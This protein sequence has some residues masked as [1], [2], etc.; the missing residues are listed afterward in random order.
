MDKIQKMLRAKT[1]EQKEKLTDE[2]V[3][4]SQVFLNMILYLLKT[5][6]KG[7][8]I[9]LIFQRK[10][11]LAPGYTDGS[12]LFASWDNSIV[13]F[14]HDRIARYFAI[15]GIIFHEI[16][17]I[18]F[19]NFKEKRKCLDR[20]L[21]GS[22]P[23]KDPVPET[24]EQAEA[25]VAV[26]KAMADL[27]YR[28]LFLEVLKDLENSATDPHDERKMTEKF[29][30]FVEKAITFA[31]ES[32]RSTL[33]PFEVLS[34]KKPV[35]LALDTAFQYARFSSIFSVDASTVEQNEVAQRILSVKEHIDNARLTD[36]MTERY[37]ELSYVL[38]AIWP[39]IEQ[40]VGEKEKEEE[41]DQKPANA[42][43]ESDSDNSSGSSAGTE[44]SEEESGSGESESDED[45]DS[46]EAEKSEKSGEPGSGSESDGQGRK[47]PEVPEMSDEQLEDLLQQV[48]N[49][50]ESSGSTEAPINR[51]SVPEETQ[52]SAPVQ[53]EN[54]EEVDSGLDKIE[55][56]IAEEKAE[57]QMDKTT[58]AELNREIKT[59]NAT[60]SHKNIPV[61]ILQHN[62]NAVSPSDVRSYEETLAEIKPYSDR[63]QRQ[64][65]NEL[66][67][68]AEDTDKF[69]Q[70]GREIDV[71]HAYRPD[72]RYFMNRKDPDSPPEMAISVLI[73]LSG[74]MIGER[75]EA[76]RKAAILLNDFTRG[77][78]IPTAITGHT[79]SNRSVLYHVFSDFNFVS[80]QSGALADIKADWNGCNRDGAAIEIAASHL[81]KRP[82]D[83][84]LLF[85]LCD[86]QPNHPDCYYGGDEAKKDIQEIVKRYKRQGI[87]T[88]ACAI[89]G[90]KEQ[91]QAIYRDS[92]LDITDLSRL[93]KT[94]TGL[95]KKRIFQK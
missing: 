23:G 53:S 85:I 59:A 95:V 7:E 43:D 8:V 71:N 1:A 82:E 88:I 79:T 74:S 63:I 58:K 68:E 94:L 77:M 12:T 90:D 28:K 60:S 87:E 67:M 44:E 56:E 78:K 34:K 81:A 69:L 41:S 4:S 45:E 29:G 40:Q 42:N 27:K 84:K 47:E 46:D 72:S 66:K 21:R 26:R 15:L 30:A 54:T 39:I 16:G 50:I 55:N 57:E 91:I 33:P 11:T 65:R 37:E 5:M 35:E 32:L 73:D 64:I 10:E 62:A 61:R 22:F 48:Q 31:A 36:S 14:Y 19:S 76:A 20:I 51:A 80:N 86:G 6:V 38:L 3:F 2:E 93:P 17:H 18:L 25:L 83:I 49:A 24:D 70:Y 75:E 89:G 13:N 9:R 52:C 92:Y